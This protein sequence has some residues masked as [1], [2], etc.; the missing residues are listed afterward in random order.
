MAEQ[1]VLELVADVSKALNDIKKFQGQAVKSTQETAKSVSSLDKGFSTLGKTIGAV[2]AAFATFSGVKGA[3]NQLGDFSKGLSEIKSI[4]D[5][6]VKSNKNLGKELLSV[7]T[8]FGTD[9]TQQTSAFYSILSAGITDA[10]K[11]QKTL[12]ASNKLAIG[13]LTSVEKSVDILTSALNVY[14]KEG[15]T[16]EKASDILFATVKKGKT[17]V[18]ELASSMGKSLPPAQGLGVGFEEVGAALATLTAGGIATAEAT[19]GLNSIFNG[20]VL[21]QS[22]LKSES[23]EVAEAFNINSFRT[24]GLSQ[25]LK[26]M[27][28]SVGGSTVEL[29][30]LLGSSQAVIAVQSL[31]R[32]EFNDLDDSIKATTESTGA[33]EEAY[34]ELE[35]SLGQQLTKLGNNFKNLALTI[36]VNFE[37]LLADALKSFNGIVLG[38]IK[39]IEQ[40]EG[41]LDALSKINY[42]QIA[43]GILSIVAAFKAVKKLGE[44]KGVVEIFN[45]ISKFKLGNLKSIAKNVSLLG[46][47]FLLVAAIAGSLAIAIDLLITNFGKFKNIL[48]GVTKSTK[49]DSLTAELRELEKSISDVQTKGAGLSGTGFLGGQIIT[50][51]NVDKLKSRAAEIKDELSTL[52]QDFDDKFGK[53]GDAEFSLESSIIDGIKNIQGAFDEV[54]IPDFKIEAEV[55][56]KQGEEGGFVG[57]QIPDDVLGGRNNSAF[58]KIFQSL[59]DSISTSFNVFDSLLGNSISGFAGLVGDAFIAVFGE[60]DLGKVSTGLAKNALQGT[61]GAQTAIKQGFSAIGENFLPGFGSEIGAIAGELTK[62]P[63]N[64]KK[65]VDQ[66]ANALPGLI[67]ALAQALPVLIERLAANS[68][69]IIVAIIKGIPKIV[70]ALI[71]AIPQIV[72]SLISALPE[73]VRALAFA[74]PEEIAKQVF[75]LNFDWEAVNESLMAVFNGIG[76]FFTN[77]FGNFT[78]KIESAGIAFR[79]FVNSI[80][81]SNIKA[82]LENFVSGISD[83]SSQFVGFIGDKLQSV[84]GFFAKVGTDLKNFIT[85]LLAVPKQILE[86]ILGPLRRGIQKI[87]DAVNPSKGIKSAGEK[88]KGGFE[89]VGEFLGFNQGGIVPGVGTKDSVATALTPG[90]LVVPKDDVTK[91]RNFLNSQGSSGGGVSE[92]LLAQAVELLGQ[93]MQV[94]TT[95]EVDGEALAEI[96]LNLDRQN[97]RT[98]A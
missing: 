46:G 1:A 85:G 90:E 84:L 51:S 71:K 16:A 74:I 9:A 27:V 17:T 67:D 63:E 30:K 96:M 68:D 4:A 57:P 93:P 86:A 97:A 47:K 26:D 80:T 2:G 55:D 21:A 94:S 82:G 65:L 42:K 28:N 38:T 88:I 77:T 50:Q 45:K 19:T 98:A 72:S 36:S 62:G 14:K 32:N 5:D 7:A 61:K 22:K 52:Q 64:V 43:T 10:A 3:V 83:K 34:K 53:Q 29:T 49:I 78:G 81:L 60:L 31:M 76:E 15:L 8:T 44:G 87:V 69:E 56:L 39:F 59:T 13:G 20:V 24:K 95:A 70:I 73:I 41:V 11:A 54:K 33:N 6:S 66:F 18:D 79:D 35:K 92:A 25:A 23:A 12:T 37:D 89:K 48:D 75:G 58:D 40:T 91:L